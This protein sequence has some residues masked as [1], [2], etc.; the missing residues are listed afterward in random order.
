MVLQ[1]KFDVYHPGKQL[2]NQGDAI[3]QTCAELGV[4]LVGYSPFSSF[5]FSLRPLDDPLVGVIASHRRSRSKKADDSSPAAVLTQWSLQQGVA[6]IPRSSS[7]EHMRATYA[8]AVAVSSGLAQ[9]GKLRGSER[10]EVLTL[11]EMSLLG[12]LANL[13]SSPLVK[14]LYGKRHP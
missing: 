13:V 4:Q 10:G 6:L 11:D 5:P 1:N 7:I 12:S 2:D 9:E 8:A 14:P 3:L